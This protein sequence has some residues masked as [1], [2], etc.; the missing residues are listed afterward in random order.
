MYGQEEIIEQLQPTG[1]V[2]E[3]PAPPVNTNSYRSVKI[4]PFS[5][6]KTVICS[7]CRFLSFPDVYFPNGQFLARPKYVLNMNWNESKFAL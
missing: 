1:Y 5:R 6:I 3:N 4:L 2:G 7:S